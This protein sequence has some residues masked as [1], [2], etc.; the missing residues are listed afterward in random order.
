M[1]LIVGGLSTVFAS[2]D[3]LYDKDDHK[4]RMQSA[5]F[6]DTV[7]LGKKDPNAFQN[8]QQMQSEIFKQVDSAFD[9]PKRRNKK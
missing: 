1:L 3:N 5:K 4:K 8:Y 9:Q 2:D 7:T 6:L